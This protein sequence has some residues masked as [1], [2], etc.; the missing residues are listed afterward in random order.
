M[1]ETIITAIISVV[2]GIGGWFVARRKNLAEIQNSELDVIEKSVRYYREI[3]DDLAKRLKESITENN[4]TN[5]LHNLAID[6]L[7]NVKNELKNLEIRF[8]LLADEN[9]NLV[10][11]LKKYKQLSGKV[12]AEN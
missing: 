4:R 3:A 9:R 10:T 12:I 2:T 8:N 11:E 1:N 7:S 6:E 5:E